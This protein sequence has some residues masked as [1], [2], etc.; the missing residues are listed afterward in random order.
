MRGD[1]ND[2]ELEQER[3]ERKRDYARGYSRC[4]NCAGSDLPGYVDQTDPEQQGVHDWVPCPMCNPNH[5]LH[6][7]ES[8]NT[9]G[10]RDPV[11]IGASPMPAGFKEALK[12][13]A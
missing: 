8:M 3:Q 12:R 9:I 11:V 4:R 6:K 13:G 1:I 7:R 5:Q 2:H 10:H